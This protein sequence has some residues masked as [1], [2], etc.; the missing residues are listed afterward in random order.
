M[1]KRAMALDNEL[2]EEIDLFITQAE[3]DNAPMIE[4]CYV[5]SAIRG[6]EQAIN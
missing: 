1:E 6:C 3:E 5:L 2:T 4:R